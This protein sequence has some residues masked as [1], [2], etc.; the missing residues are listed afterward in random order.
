VISRAGIAKK[1]R[2]LSIS[3]QIVWPFFVNNASL[4]ALIALVIFFSLAN[5]QFFSLSNLFNILDLVSL[6]GI[7]SLAMS[8]VLMIGSIDLSVEGLVGLCGIVTSFLVRNFVNANDFG[9]YALPIS[10]VVGFAFGIANGII[11]SKFKVPSFMATLGVGFIATGVG[12]LATRGNPIVITDWSFRQLGIGRVGFI[13]YTFLITLAVI[14]F[15][16]FLHERTVFG[17]HMLA[18]GGDEII[19]KHLG[20]N[21]DKI[22]II[23]FALVGMLYGL[24]GALLTAKLGS[25]DINAPI[26]F[27]F[28]SIGACVLGGIAI[29]GG[30]GSVFKAIVGAFM[31]TILRNGMII[32]GVSPYVQQGVIGV[33]LIFTVALTI[34]RR[35]IRIMK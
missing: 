29:T 4:F 17:R 7:T 1:P 30:V 34:D 28:D 16:W 9:F 23:V 21:V 27:T 22:K 26:G 5:P 33:I 8:F 19:A 24:V 3:G 14:F 31:L 11:L 10:M 35:K 13:P 25:G 18:L 20:V 6:I 15:M 12:I 32:L 2:V